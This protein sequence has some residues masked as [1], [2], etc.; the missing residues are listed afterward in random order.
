MLLNVNNEVR[1]RNQRSA[2]INQLKEK[3]M[4][5]KNETAI[6]YAKGQTDLYELKKSELDNLNAELNLLELIQNYDS[7]Q[8][9]NPD[10]DPDSKTGIL[11]WI[12]YIIFCLWLFGRYL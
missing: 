5:L 7:F 2:R 4:F 1:Q 12:V 8:N 10:P 6:S 3:I 11:F 9:V